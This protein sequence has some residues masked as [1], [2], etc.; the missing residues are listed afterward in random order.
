MLDC[1]AKLPFPAYRDLN[2]ADEVFKLIRL[3]LLLCF[4]AD[5]QEP[6]TERVTPTIRCLIEERLEQCLAILEKLFVKEW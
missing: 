2:K 5:L 6:S 4:Q 1:L 3:T